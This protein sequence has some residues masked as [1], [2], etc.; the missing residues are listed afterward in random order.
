MSQTNYNHRFINKEILP[1]LSALD[2]IN[3]SND[4]LFLDFIHNCSPDVAQRDIAIASIVISL[5]QQRSHHMSEYTPSLLLLN[6]SHA[7]CDP[8]HQLLGNLS[9][10]KLRNE[11]KFIRSEQWLGLTS[12]NAGRMLKSFN[13]LLS[14]LPTY[15]FFG[16]YDRRSAAFLTSQMNEARAIEYGSEATRPYS[17]LWHPEYGYFS[18]GYDIL[19]GRINGAEDWKAF[20]DDLIKHPSKLLNPIGLGQVGRKVV[21]T[22]SISGSITENQWDGEL[23]SHIIDLGLPILCIP[24]LTTQPLKVRYENI[25]KIF[26][27]TWEWK[28]AGHTRTSLSITTPF[29]W[30]E[31]TSSEVRKR[32]RLIPGNG[33][34]DFSLLFVLRQLISVCAGI[35]C[36]PVITKNSSAIMWSL[37]AATYRAIALGVAALA[38]H[39]FGF[40]PGCPR[41]KALKVLR[42]IQS[43]GSMTMNEI[44]RNFHLDSKEQRDLL[45]ERLAAENLI[46]INGRTVTSTTFEGFVKALQ[47]RIWS[48]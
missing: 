19:V 7:Q 30:F 39:V 22:L 40:D 21:K 18:N 31:R 17:K 10:E 33:D 25:M 9:D 32:L 27:M 8:I 4:E 43:A 34:Y 26:F 16:K 20:R 1:T 42:G 14:E 6:A 13:R 5:W 28:N 38:W 44:R 11:A 46:R 35:S 37:F 15:P 3:V 48:E 29:D 41:E 36:H 47:A 24:H 45:L 12:S 23:V 2:A